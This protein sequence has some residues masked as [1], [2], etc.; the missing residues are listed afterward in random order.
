[1][2]IKRTTTMA[3][4]NRITKDGRNRKRTKQSSWCSC[5]TL[6]RE[7]ATTY[8]ISGI[9]FFKRS[10]ESCK[11]S[12]ACHLYIGTEAATTVGLKMTYY[13]KLLANT[14]R[15]SM[16]ITAGA[17]G[18]SI[19]PCLNFRAVVP[20]DSPAFSLLD[21]SRLYERFP[22]R[23]LIDSNEL[24]EYFES[25]LREIYELFRSKAASPNDVDEDGTTLLIVI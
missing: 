8:S 6:R 22:R 10:T 21:P 20:R 17:G 18:F 14:V 24:C 5:S 2:N 1:M 15:A 3:A 19:S 25:A 13:G 16:S 23:S 4:Q 11:H 12:V 7:R 9:E